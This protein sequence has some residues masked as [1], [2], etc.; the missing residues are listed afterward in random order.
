[1][2]ET[3]KKSLVGWLVFSL[4]AVWVFVVYAI[5]IWNTWTDPQELE[6]SSWSILTSANWN[7]MLANMNSLNEKT[8]LVWEQIVSTDTNTVTVSWLNYNLNWPYEWVFELNLFD[9]SA[10]LISV[11]FN[12]DIS[13]NYSSQQISSYSTGILSHNNT[14][15]SSASV[16]A[17]SSTASFI[18]STVL[19]STIW[20][21]PTWFIVS[22]FRR[23]DWNWTW[24]RQILQS[25]KTNFT[26]SNIDSITLKSDTAWCIKAWS[27]LRIYKK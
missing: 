6:S 9:T 2:K 20:L 10:C 18:K 16:V 3:I 14:N 26:V 27:K 5:T 11:Y 13:T 19:S 1:M 25:V 12:W 4:T 15:N 23:T 21:T 8:N 24:L 17:W 7:K 22:E